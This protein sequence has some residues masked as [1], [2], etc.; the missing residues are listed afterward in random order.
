MPSPLLPRMRSGLTL[1]HVIASRAN[2]HADR[3]AVSF[4][5]NEGDAVA[6]RYAELW[7][8]A[9]AVAE[10]I[11]TA[12]RHGSDPKFVLIALPNGPEYVTSF[13]GCLLAGAP[14]VPFYPPTV[15]TGRV[16]QAFGQRLHQIMRDCRPSM[17]ILPGDLVERAQAGLDPE[18]VAGTLWVPAE[19]LPTTPRDPH[20]VDHVAARPEDLA[21]LQYTSGST[22]TPKGVMVTHANLVHNAAEF[23]FAGGMSEGESLTTWLP[24]FHDMGL[25]GALC[26]PLAAG[27]TIHMTTPADF[28][29][30]P[31]AWLDTLSRTRSA[32]TMAPNFALDLCVRWVGEEQRD[33]LDLSGLRHLIIGAEPVRATTIEAFVKAF[34]RCG[35]DPGAISPG[36]GMAEHTLCM[37][38]TNERV[39]PLLREVSAAR[40]REGV[41]TPA[42][43]EPATVIVGC[44]TDF[45]PD[46]ETVIVDPQRSTPVPDGHIGEIWS[47]GPSVARGYWGMPEASA[48]TFAAEIPGD[49]RQFLRTGDLGLKID[50]VL[51]IV[52][53]MKDLII[54]HGANHYPQD[55]EYTAERAH[56]DV[57]AA[58]TVAFS[59]PRPDSEGVVL[60]FEL[61][62]YGPAVDVTAVLDTVRRALVE[63]HGLE[64]AAVAIVRKGQIPKTTSGKVRRRES[65]RRWEAGEFEVVDA[66]S[67][68]Y[69]G[70]GEALSLV[71]TVA[72]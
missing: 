52:G 47:T 20:S 40:L 4:Q 1:P 36:Y 53:R 8:R 27:M 50:G 48:Q 31:F 17:V 30:R 5:T 11:R 35:L 25:I 59:V 60:L 33:S 69:Q 61:A 15:A 3:V 67:A 54:Q 43:D 29:R 39:G 37:T 57:R 9:A 10:L 72:S 32:V 64:L 62:R 23:A 49:G 21:L 16:A 56:P 68:P 26:T 38:I 65:A 7:R 6:L 46:I 42:V 58:G 28:V 45:A 41:A 19:Q 63:E 13:Y 2:R 24:L 71:P 44:G 34:E 18:L 70:S 14:G 22:T 51:F 12:P 66:W 55:L